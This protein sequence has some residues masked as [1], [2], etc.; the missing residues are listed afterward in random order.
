MAFFTFAAGLFLFGLTQS[1]NAVQVNAL[2]CMAS[3]F[4]NAYCQSISLQFPCSYANEA[5]GVLFGYAP[6]LFPTPSR[7]TGDAI[8]ACCQRVFGLFAPIIA[9]YSPAADTPDGPVFAAGGIYLLYVIP[10]LL[11][12]KY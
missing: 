6:E 10:L 3:F 7:G 11:H 1:R 5:D 9:V 2:T 4:S 12:Y 8:V